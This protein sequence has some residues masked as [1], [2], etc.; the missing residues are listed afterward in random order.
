MPMAARRRCAATAAGVPPGL[1]FSKALR[2]NG[3]P[4]ETKAGI[5]DAEVKDRIVKLRLTDP[6]E[7]V[8]D[9]TIPVKGTMLPMNNINTGVPH[10]VHYV[11]D[12]DACDVFGYG[13]EIRYHEYYKPAGTN[14]NFVKVL[15]R[16]T[17]QVRTYERGVE[18]ETL[19]CGT[20]AVA[21]ALI[22][23]WKGLVEP[24][25]TVI[26]RSNEKLKIHFEKKQNGISKGLFRRW[27]DPGL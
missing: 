22:S 5:I 10:A 23:C 3:C 27:N 4:F 13:R 15:D 26:V 21:S 19:A 16:G 9:Y 2:L 12:L 18:A 25:V 24:P 17:I 6:T 20:G 1:P 8:V 14:V 11:S 7:P